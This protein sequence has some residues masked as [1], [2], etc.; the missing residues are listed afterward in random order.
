M[1]EIAVDLIRHCSCFEKKEPPIFL[2]ELF[3]TDFNFRF[4]LATGNFPGFC[5]SIA[6]YTK[7][8]LCHQHLRG[9]LEPSC[10]FSRQAWQVTS[11]PKSLR[12][13]GNDSVT[14]F[15]SHDRFLITLCISIRM[16]QGFSLTVIGCLIHNKDCNPANFHD[17]SLRRVSFI[18]YQISYFEKSNRRMSLQTDVTLFMEIYD[19]NV[20]RLT[21]FKKQYDEKTVEGIPS[22]TY[23]AATCGSVDCQTCFVKS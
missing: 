13:T 7:P 14:C 2:S 1:I 12:T 23:L 11:H 22:F 10:E 16:P 6:F 9:G 3:Q 20:D 21:I 15:I 4:S 18:K 19:G 17:M 8:R 5:C